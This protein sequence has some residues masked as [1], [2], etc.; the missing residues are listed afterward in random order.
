MPNTQIVAVSKSKDALKDS[1]QRVPTTKIVFISS[2]STVKDVIELRNFFSIEMKIPTEIRTLGTK[3]EEACRMFRE[4]ENPILHLIDHDYVN[5][6]LVNAAVISGVPVYF[7]NGKG[8]ERI[9]TPEVKF[10]ELI[11]DVQVE[12]LEELQEGPLSLLEL[13]ERID[14][15]ES[16]LYYYLHGKNS[17]KGLVSLGLVKDGDQ[18]ELSETGRAVVSS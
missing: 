12:I 9:S 16:M 18:I 14:C 4:F 15:D 1:L 7:S 10:K 5:Y 6:V 17:L 13:A 3:T 8:A 11:S 2:P